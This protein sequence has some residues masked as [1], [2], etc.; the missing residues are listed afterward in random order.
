MTPTGTNVIIEVDK[1]ES[2]SEGG[3]VIPENSKEKQNRGKIVAVGNGR[4]SEY[5]AWIYPNSKVDQS[6]LFDTYRA[7]TFTNDGKEYVVVD[8]SSVLVVF[9]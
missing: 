7:H 9:D 2:M 8:Q 3:I 5:G 6:V 1:P 4:T